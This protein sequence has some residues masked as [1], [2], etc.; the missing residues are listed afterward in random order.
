MTNGCAALGFGRIR[1]VTSRLRALGASFLFLHRRVCVTRFIRRRRSGGALAPVR[2][3]PIRER[4]RSILSTALTSV[5]S[6][7]SRAVCCGKTQLVFFDFNCHGKKKSKVEI[8][9]PST[10]THTPNQLGLSKPDLVAFPFFFFL[11]KYSRDHTVATTIHDGLRHLHWHFVLSAS[12]HLVI[13]ILFLFLFFHPQSSNTTDLCPTQIL[14]C[15]PDP[16]RH[17]EQR[18][19]R[20]GRH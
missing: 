2:Y 3:R 4:R 13:N 19:H 12:F 1:D 20:S 15:I 14:S 6:R 17:G 7:T 11:P 16:L 9:S 5:R 10:H 8:N 18:R